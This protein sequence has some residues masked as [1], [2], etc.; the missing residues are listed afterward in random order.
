MFKE[1][2]GPSTTHKIRGRMLDGL[3]CKRN[4]ITAHWDSSALPNTTTLQ[5]KPLYL[6][7]PLSTLTKPLPSGPS[8]RYVSSYIHHQLTSFYTGRLWHQLKESSMGRKNLVRGRRSHTS[9]RRDWAKLHYNKQLIYGHALGS[10]VPIIACGRIF[11]G[12]NFVSK[13]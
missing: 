7:L 13:K 11:S 9:G 4:I 2:F 10:L 8:P 12:L 3:K 1:W 5:H 6:G